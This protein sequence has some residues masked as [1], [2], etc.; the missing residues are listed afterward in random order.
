[1]TDVKSPQNLRIFILQHDH[2]IM[3]NLI[4]NDL[5]IIARS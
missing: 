5:I 3:P 1:M 2:N 4:N